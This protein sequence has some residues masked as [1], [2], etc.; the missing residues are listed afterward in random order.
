MQALLDLIFAVEGS[1]SEAA[2]FLGYANFSLYDT[3]RRS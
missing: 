1:V 3:K 2:K